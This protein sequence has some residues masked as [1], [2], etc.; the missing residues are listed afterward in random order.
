MKILFLVK[1][2]PSLSESFV[3]QQ[4]VNLLDEGYEVEIC[5]EQNPEE[6]YTHD[7]FNEYNLISKTHYIDPINFDNKFILR[8]KSLYKILKGFLTKPLK[9]IR[10][11]YI[12]IRFGFEY[13]YLYYGLTIANKK[14][15]ICHCHFGPS[16]LVG[17]FLKQSGIIKKLVTSFHGYDVTTY[18]HKHGHHI[19][20]K[21]FELSDI[22]T[23]NSIATKDKLI[24]L[25]CPISKLHRIPMGIDLEKI[26]FKIRNI[27][28]NE[29]LNI[30]SVGRLVEMKGREYAIKAVTK[31]SREIPNIRYNIVGD[32]PLHDTLAKLI[33]DLNMQE[34][35]HL[36]GWIDDHELNR[37]Y[38]ES[39]I[40]LHPSVTASDGNQ[41]GQ[42]VVLLEAQAHGIP[43]I[44]TKHNA[45]IET[46]ADGKSGYLLPEKDVDSIYEK[47]LFLAKNPSLWE[48]MGLEGRNHAEKYETKTICKELIK[49]YIKANSE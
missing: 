46:V 25:G 35:I 16:G 13:R 5:A 20:N 11:S 42:G 44:A 48:M 2:F 22:C 36:L 45:F 47:L 39:H 43:I 30:L 23:Y 7:L 49:L 33:K 27:K 3:I 37:L 6:T 12:L 34:I 19:Y 24:K 29:T 41:E 1:K 21:L 17:A 28:Q 10:V 18:V 38:N 32:G 8:K 40:F 31:L 14:F 9:T 26:K 4:I 15:D